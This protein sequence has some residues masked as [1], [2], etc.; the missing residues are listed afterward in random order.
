[1]THTLSLLVVLFFSTA[2]S[3]DYPWQESQA[4][5]LSN[6]DLAYTPRPFAFQPGDS[7]RYID[8]ENGD[9]SYPG[10]RDQPWKHH[11]WDP[12]ATANAQAAATEVHTYVFRGG[13]TYRGHFEIPEG[14]RGTADLSHPSDPRSRLGR[15]TGRHQR[16]GVG[17]W[18]DSGGPGSALTGRNDSS[19]GKRICSQPEEEVICPV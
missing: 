9:D 19:S 6:G 1:M 17:H 18:M 8:F 16:R 7:Q 13:V 14:A 3:A 15:G 5:V 2:V 10:T 12:D 4:R 11:P